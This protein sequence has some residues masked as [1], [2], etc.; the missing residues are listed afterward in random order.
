M[1]AES[2]KIVTSLK[3]ARTAL[4]WTQQEFA[5]RSG[6]SLVSIARME[7]GMMS[8]RLS[9][10]SK[11]KAALSEAGVRIVNESPAG[12][13]SLYVDPKALE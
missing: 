12:G 10:L 2:Q 13:F 6:V 9:T 11:L 1:D 5:S 7:T 3:T 4:N 8:P